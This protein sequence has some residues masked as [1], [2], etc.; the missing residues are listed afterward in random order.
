MKCDCETCKAHAAAANR[1]RKPAAKG[2]A[3]P[4]RAREALGLGV[5][6]VAL[7][8]LTLEQVDAIGAACV[9]ERQRRERRYRLTSDPRVF[10]AEA[11]EAEAEADESDRL[12]DLIRSSPV[13]RTDRQRSEAIDLLEDLEA[14]CA[15]LREELAHEAV[16]HGD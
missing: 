8:T 14:R 16:K 3:K 9:R 10:E 12:M 7:R 11:A 6:P 15:S 5:S 4:P 2:A 13:L 1:R